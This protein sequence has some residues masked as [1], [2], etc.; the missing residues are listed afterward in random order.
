M[1]AAA[2]AAEMTA[3][4]RRQPHCLRGHL[5]AGDNAYVIPTTRQI[6][7]RTCRR[8]AARDCMRTKRGTPPERRRVSP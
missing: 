1:D 4:P 8:A 2:G 7:C 3:K 5:V 6:V